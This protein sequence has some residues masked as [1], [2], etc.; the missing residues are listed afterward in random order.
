MK[1]RYFIT[2]TD[3]DVGKTHITEALLRAAQQRGLTTL[4]L[5]PLAAGAELIDGQWSNDDARRLQAVSSLKLPYEQ[6]NPVLLRAALAPHLAA[7]ME[8]RR[9]TVQS[10]AGFCRG[11]LMTH[12]AQLTLIEGAGGWRVPLNDRETLADLAIELNLE[13]I[14]V[15][16][17]TLG[18]LNH[19]LLTAEAIRRD[20]LQLA[21]W[22]AN[23]LDPQMSSLE[24]NIQ[25]LA[26]RLPA[27]LLGTMPFQSAD[28]APPPAWLGNRFFDD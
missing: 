2:G 22:V 6:V 4:G 5:K 20:G 13:V 27:P 17:M 8:Q 11:T 25:T 15:V 24:A 19:A 14:L 10:L 16:G 1:K 28:E 21:G 9:L 26:K 23:C 7:E 18:C 3:T 12:R